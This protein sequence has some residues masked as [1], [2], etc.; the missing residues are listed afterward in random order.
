MS[1]PSFLLAAPT[2]AELDRWNP[3]SSCYV[4]LIRRRY[5]FL[6][7]K[8]SSS[9][10]HSS[11]LQYATAPSRRADDRVNSGKPLDIWRLRMGESVLG[12]YIDK[13]N[14]YMVGG[15]YTG[16]CLHPALATTS[17]AAPTPG[18]EGTLHCTCLGQSHRVMI[19]CIKYEMDCIVGNR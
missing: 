8:R 5:E 19:A 18:E 11:R 3:S 9:S 12:K 6:R 17:A 2:M 13:G 16:Q 14:C 1:S 10:H 4:W 15:W 7:Q